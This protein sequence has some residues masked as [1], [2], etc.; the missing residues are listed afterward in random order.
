MFAA[1]HAL[2][3]PLLP[4]DRLVLSHQQRRAEPPDLMA[5][6]NGIAA[7][8][9]AATG[10][11]QQG[12]T[13]RIW[14]RWTMS[15]CWRRQAGRSCQAKKPLWLTPRTRHIRLIGKSAF[16]A[17]MKANFTDLPPSRRRRRHCRS[18]QWRNNDGL[19]SGCRAPVSATASASPGRCRD[20]QLVPD[21]SGRWLGQADCLTPKLWRRTVSVSHRTPPCSSVGALHLFRASPAYLPKIARSDAR[22][23]AV[24]R[25]SP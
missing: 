10:P 17:S 5:F 15:C 9:Q 1:R 14:A 24:R 8:A 21:A 3:A 7:H 6:I 13:V 18:D 12:K 23:R 22:L 19:F 16:P 2:D 4:R 11:V 25:G 20:P